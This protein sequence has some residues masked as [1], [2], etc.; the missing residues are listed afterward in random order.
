MIASVITFLKGR[1]WWIDKRFKNGRRAYPDVIKVGKLYKER[2][3]VP[4]VRC[5]DCE[6][7]RMDAGCC[8]LNGFDEAEWVAVEPDGFCKW[9]VKDGD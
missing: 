8:A 2:E 6:H 3:Y 9:G 4:I 1:E 7:A 5:R